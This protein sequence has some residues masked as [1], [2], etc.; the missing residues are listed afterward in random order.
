MAVTAQLQIADH[1][2]EIGR[3]MPR[4]GLSGVGAA[5]IAGVAD[6]CRWERAKAARLIGQ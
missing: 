4:I 1:T 2:L 6:R 3:T 5:G